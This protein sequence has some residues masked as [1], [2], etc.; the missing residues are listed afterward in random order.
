MS[1][2]VGSASGGRLGAFVDELA[3]A[4]VRDAIVCPG[5]R[6]T[7]LALTLRANPRI[8]VRVLIDERSAAFF[9]LGIARTTRRAVALLATS[10][11]AVVNF[12]PAVVEASL[13]RVPLVVLTAD[14][15]DELRDRG[16]PQT[17]DQNRLYGS[18]VKWYSELALGDEAADS[19]A[20][21]RFVAARAVATALAGPAGPVHLN[22]PLGDPLIPHGDL[23]A[24]GR[25]GDGDDAPFASV[26][27]GR[28]TLDAAQIDAIADALAANP[29]GLIVAG[30]LDDPASHEPIARIAAATGYPVV[31]DPLSGMRLGTHDRSQVIVH[32][33][34]ILRPGSWLDAHVP[35]MVVRFGAMPTSKWV[36][37]MLRTARPDLI[38]F[39]AD[40]GWRESALVPAAFVRADAESACEI[41]EAVSLRRTRTGA[42]HDTRWTRAWLDAD[43]A[44]GAALDAWLGG[45]R[46]PFEGAPFRILGELLP[47][48]SVL[49][50]GNSMPVRDMDAWLPGGDRAVRVL[51][52]RGANGIDGVISTA[53]GSAAS[54]FAA[55]SAEPD[56]GRYVL[57]LGDVS[58][59]HDVGALVTARLHA[60]DLLVIAINN[61]GGGI[62]S[63]LPQGRATFSAVGLPEHYEELFGT[64]HGIALGPI[65]EAFGFRHRAADWAGLS[66][67]ISDEI[68]RPGL[69]VI[70]L[71]TE[72]ARNAQLHD[73]A[74]AAV[75]EALTALAALSGEAA[76]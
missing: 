32:G 64:P 58:F 30:P 60:A 54:V 55:G 39:D 37:E 72:R 61:D 9:A 45:L 35:D 49:W 76:P 28:P 19:Q 56:S 69:R 59:L 7:P 1:G 22:M 47:D 63:L 3:R 36:A 71:R 10:G 52:N 5:S 25:D 20:N 31:A 16:A 40:G 46:E 21:A 38:V 66:A 26:V 24:S 15:P 50:S 8:H 75:S 67:A 57:V 2:V 11:T 51:A 74:A 34:H 53:L 62:F 65:V 17:I 29:R 4:G 70:E 42:A 44:A 48:G 18:H 23:P 33:D 27:S 6:S 12:A 73:E 41:A 14:R 68:G 13:A 43:A